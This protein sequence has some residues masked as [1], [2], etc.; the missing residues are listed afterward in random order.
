[1]LLAAADELDIDLNRSFMVGDRWG[2]VEA[3]KAAGCRATFFIDYG[4]AESLRSE[5]DY[6]V[7]SLPSA[8][9]IILE[10]FKAE[11]AA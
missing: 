1:M 9:A 6:R 3:G 8:A 4:Y 2:D 5:P 11:K 10:L 7:T